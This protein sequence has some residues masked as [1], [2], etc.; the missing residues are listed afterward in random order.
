MK[1][2]TW[3]LSHAVKRSAERRKKGW[4]FLASLSVDIAMTQEAG[5][6]IG[7]AESSIIGEKIGEVNWATAVVSYGPKIGRLEQPIRP[8]WDRNAEFYI[9]DAAR[10]G[11]LAIAVAESWDDVPIIVISLYG[12]LRYADQSVLRAA[13]DILPIFDTSLRRRV[14]IGGDFN[15]HTHSNVRSERRRAGPILSVLESFG[16]YDLVRY[17]MDNSMFS[18]GEQKDLQLCPCGD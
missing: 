7:S 17:S 18:Q 1:I 15:I 9:P 10:G 8:S 6:P 5:L 13:S 12:R 14:V 16:F 3:N 11:T 2:A 4:D